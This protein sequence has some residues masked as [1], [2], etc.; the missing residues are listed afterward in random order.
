VKQLITLQ[1]PE[2]SLAIAR[3]YTIEKMVKVHLDL[4]GIK[5]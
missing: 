4:L 1:N 5:S 3:Q 2:A